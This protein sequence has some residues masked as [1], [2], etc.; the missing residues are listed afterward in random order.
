MNCDKVVD[1]ETLD[2]VKTAGK[3][4]VGL[5]VFSAVAAM[6]AVGTVVAWY[7]CLPHGNQTEYRFSVCCDVQEGVQETER[8]GSV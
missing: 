6:A 3:I 2:S 4:T 8:K 1:A 7:V 5:V